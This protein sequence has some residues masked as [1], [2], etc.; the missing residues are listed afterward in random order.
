MAGLRAGVLLSGGLL[1]WLLSQGP[2]LPIDGR[3]SI[4]VLRIWFWCSVEMSIASGWGWLAKQLDLPLVVSGGSNLNTP[5][6][7][8]TRKPWIRAR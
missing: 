1:V 3:S 4:A 8:S 2:W 5:L 7:S 6:G